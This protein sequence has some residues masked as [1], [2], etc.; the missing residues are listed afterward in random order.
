MSINLQST[1]RVHDNLGHF[2]PHDC[3]NFFVRPHTTSPFGLG[4]RQHQRFRG[5]RHFVLV[6]RLGHDHR[7][8][9]HQQHVGHVV[10]PNRKWPRGW[11]RDSSGKSHRQLQHLLARKRVH[12]RTGRLHPLHFHVGLCHSTHPHLG[13][14]HPRHQ[15]TESM[16][17]RF[18]DFYPFIRQF[19]C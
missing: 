14:L 5:G 6:K 1:G 8:L 15:E 11:D 13:L 4:H 19:N 10:Y 3:A 9:D 7:F 18:V 12:E 2:F 17:K 16:H